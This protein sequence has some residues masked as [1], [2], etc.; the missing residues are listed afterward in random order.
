MTAIVTLISFVF[1]IYGSILHASMVIKRLKLY[2]EPNQEK[3]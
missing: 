3:D 2:S 1:G